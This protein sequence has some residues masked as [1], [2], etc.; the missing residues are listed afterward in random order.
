M[1]KKVRKEKIVINQVAIVTIA[2]VNVCI[3]VAMKLVEV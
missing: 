1:I 3:E 2:D